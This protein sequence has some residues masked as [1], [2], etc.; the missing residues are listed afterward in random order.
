MK[1]PPSPLTR[2]ERVAL[3]LGTGSAWPCYDAG[4]DCG[5][6]GATTDNC[7]HTYFSNRQRTAEWERGKR[8]GEHAKRRA[9][10]AGGK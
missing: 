10:T 8:D 3:A 5:L 2:F 9:D 6:N 4:Y 7:H 1:A